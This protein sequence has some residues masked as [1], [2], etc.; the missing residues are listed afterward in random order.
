MESPKIYVASLTDYNNGRLE[1]KFFDFADYSDA[2]ELMKAI[3]DMLKELT[4]K[5]ND[6]DIRE[7]YAVHDYE[8]IPSSLAS[9][10]MGER[11][12]EVIYELMDVAE[13]SNIP[14]DV[15]M[16][17]AGDVGSDDYQ[18]IVD[19]LVMVV[20]GSDETDIVYQLEQEMGSLGNDFWK[21]HIYIDDVT[22]RVMYGE[23]VDRYREDILYENPDMDEN[24]A[25]EQA[26][27]M[28]SDEAERRK[29]DLIGYLEEMG[30]EDIPTFVSKD[31]ESAWNDISNDYDVIHTTNEMYVF[32][33]NYSVGGVV[34]GGLLGAYLGYNYGITSKRKKL[35]LGG[36]TNSGLSWHQDHKRHNKSESYEIPMSK[37]KFADGGNIGM[38][39][40][41][42]GDSARVKSENKMGVIVK[43]Y[44]RKFH[45]RFA[46]G[47]EKTYD[48]S[49]LEFY[50]FDEEEFA[51]GGGIQIGGIYKVDGKDYLIDSPKQNANG[52]Y[53]SWM[54]YEV[55]Y[56]MKQ[57]EKHINYER[58]KK[59]IRLKSF[60][61]NVKRENV[62]SDYFADGGKIDGFTNDPIFKQGNISVQRIGGST[63]WTFAINNKLKG[64]VYNAYTKGQAFKKAKNETFA[65]GGMVGREIEF[66]QYGESRTGKIYEDYGDDTYG[67]QSGTSK[68]L[69]EK[70]DITR[71]IEP[72]MKRKFG[73]FEDGGGVE[74]FYGNDNSL[75][76]SSLSKEEISI[77]LENIANHY[78]VSQNE[79]YAEVTDFESKALYEY[80]TDDSLRM[81]IYREMNLRFSKGGGV[82]EISEEDAKEELEKLADK[83]Y[84]SLRIGNDGSINMIIQKT[85]RSLISSMYQPYDSYKDALRSY[86]RVSSRFEQGGGV[87][88][89]RVYIEYLNKDKGFKRDRIEF[90]SY[91]EA[92]E[93]GK[94]HFEKFNPDMINYFDGGGNVRDDEWYQMFNHKNNYSSWNT[95]SLKRGIED[96]DIKEQ[97][98]HTLTSSEI[99]EIEAMFKELIKRGETY[100]LGD[101]QNNLR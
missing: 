25:E 82:G 86:V 6:G 4:K 73:F 2:S 44:G 76:L 46:N 68:V 58:T 77:I 5:Y 59:A 53:T 47:K 69:V 70:G 99:A 60:P 18:A 54:A 31:Y 17:R 87:E 50:N 21:N 26:E 67:V 79:I 29:D 81:K 27:E 32:S 93:W 36:S 92:V 57:G 91:K 1:G 66:N 52:Q 98:G 48:A 78:G 40:A 85:N 84:V 16:E 65:S 72:Q 30:Y 80:V 14:L 97:N 10:Y 8:N 7:E 49:E 74:D 38:S 64:R 100:K 56:D 101:K 28:A 24:E 96:Y 63:M 71:T 61:N 20:D 37:R 94:K 88:E 34:I 23:D 12:F 41:K 43:D 13:D 95:Y 62:S 45:L 55:V 19:S 89:E 3:D 15:L 42:V 39:K 90:D 75:Y 51:E 83:Q 11:D 33:N 35:A 22:E 9:E